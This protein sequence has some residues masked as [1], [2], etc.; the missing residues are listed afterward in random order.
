MNKQ[1]KMYFFYVHSKRN[2]CNQNQL[3]NVSVC[4]STLFGK[5]EAL[6]NIP[7]FHKWEWMKVKIESTF[8]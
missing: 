3:A 2:L 6:G 7:Q 5:K 1:L 8:C 4:G